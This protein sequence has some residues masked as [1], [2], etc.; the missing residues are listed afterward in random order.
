[1]ADP[2]GTD[3]TG[4]VPP[5]PAAAP[6]P[7]TRTA[8]EPAAMASADKPTGKDAPRA[9]KAPA[10]KGGADKGATGKA[11]ASKGPPAKDR[12]ASRAA[13]HPAV[14]IGSGIFTFL[15]LACVVGGLGFWWGERALTAPGPLT[16]EKTVM[17]PRGVGIAEMGELLERE[18]VVRDARM[19]QIGKYVRQAEVKAGEYVF[20]PGQS[21]IS[22]LDT[23]SSG[24]V[25]LHRVS[26]PEGLTSQQIVAR[27]MENEMLSGTPAVPKEGTLLPDTYR[28]PRGYSRE[29]LVQQ[30]AEAQKKMLDG[31][32]AKRDPSLP[33]K[34][35]QDLVILAS[36]VEKETG[37]A[38]ERNRVAAVFVNRLN[39]KMKLQSDP[40]I[41]YGIV[42][43]KGSL[44]RPI[45][46]ADINMPTAYNTYAIEG[47]PP[48]PIANPG[49]E[50]LAAVAS[51][52]KTND[53]F[54]VADGTG[55]HAFAETLADHNKNVTRWRA[56]EAARSGGAPAAAPAP[57]GAAPAPLPAV[58]ASPAPLPRAAN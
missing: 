1:M 37:E 8:E 32:W 18:S 12:R 25:V 16:A 48:G 22:V 28:V 23:L 30:M 51:P 3:T 10:G 21:I 5:T 50:A 2:D 45:S 38:D 49:R 35:P 46:R 40:T 58:P 13:E 14:T 26:I 43:G 54:F 36:I 27:L 33:L 9:A 56:I 55:G 15:L 41:I 24:K 34:N 57:G 11:T 52:A 53:L 42:G 7:A 6:A 47:L 44:G 19:F 39:K 31:L 4:S 20:K 17:I 29:Q